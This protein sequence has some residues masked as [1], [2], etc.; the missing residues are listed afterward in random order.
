M[1]NFGDPRWRQWILPE[2]AARPLVWRALDLGVNFFDTADMYS[3]GVGEEVTGRLLLSHARRAEVV[4]ATKVYMPT[5]A[6]INQRGLSRLHLHQAVDG[7]LRRLGTDY[8]DL[9]QIHRYDPDTPMEETLETL[10]DLIRAGKVRYIG[11]SSM[12]AWQFARYLYTADVHGWTRFVCMQNHYN[13]V[14]REEERE[15]LPLCRAEGVGVTPWSPL[16]RGFLA[17]N[18]RRGGGGD[19]V[20][21]MN[22]DRAQRYYFRP[23][24]FEVAERVAEI[25]RGR[26]VSA[27]QVAL[28]WLLQQ[29]GIAAPVVGVSSLEQ[30]EQAVAAT[31][32]RL[33][34]DEC[35]GLEAPY[36]PKETFLDGPSV[37]EDLL[38]ASYQ[39]P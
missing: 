18:R 6:G 13:L 24:D 17:G 16:A 10:H 39:A 35:C 11:A 4:I 28:A 27:A 1:M 31:A 7:S 8:I 20:R 2:E 23:A 33:T 22:D 34:K 3:N 19:T 14:Y 26:G 5:G 9:Y 25:G 21:A 38:P 36:Q 15:M 29:P 12:A 32:L 30:L 37:P